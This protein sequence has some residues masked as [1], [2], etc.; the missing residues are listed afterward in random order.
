MSTMNRNYFY[1]SQAL[2][3]KKLIIKI[4]NQGFC[5]NHEERVN[6]NKERFSAG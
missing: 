5:Y 3:G 1:L 4:N 2:Y 6:A